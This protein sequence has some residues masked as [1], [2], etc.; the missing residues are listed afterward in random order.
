MRVSVVNLALVL[1]CALLLRLWSLGHG[2]PGGLLDDEREVLARVIA[3]LQNNV[4]HPGSLDPAPL[5]SYLLVPVAVVRFLAGVASGTFTSVGELT[6]GALAFW[7]RL[8]VALCG[9]ATVWIVFQIGL[10]WGARHALLGAGLMTVMPSHV[11]ASHFVTPDVPAVFLLALGFLLSLRAA[12]R[13][14]WPAF[15]LAGG[16]AGLAAAMS[17][18]AALAV[19]LPLTAAWMTLT[20]VP[21]R[22]VCGAAAVAAAAALY[23]ASCPFVLLDLPWFLNDAAQRAAARAA[24]DPPVAW[25]VPVGHLTTELGGPAMLLMIGGTILGVVRAVKGPG[26]TRWTLATGFPI[27]ALLTGS[28]LS[29]VDVR[30]LTLLPA[31]CLLA[32]IAVVSGVSQLRRFEIARAPRT[33]LIAALTVA[34][35]LPPLIGALQV[36]RALAQPPVVIRAV[37]DHE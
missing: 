22:R 14:T 17:P 21:S 30:V 31:A 12:E 6:P 18:V 20:A 10:R 3:A 37:I 25:W 34:A 9:T 29:L 33:A 7:G 19:A 27:V 5:L 11:R 2:L 16:A 1:L 26:R 4:W 13:P 32:A 15:A 35:V 28:T 23:L 24:T 8:T 36:A